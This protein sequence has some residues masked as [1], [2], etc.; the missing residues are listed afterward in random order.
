MHLIRNIL[1]AALAVPVII[2]VISIVFGLWLLGM[3]VTILITGKIGLVV[4]T[5]VS[6]F[7]GYGIVI[8]GGYT[9]GENLYKRYTDK[10]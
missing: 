3:H 5:L 1:I 4:Y 7:I 10:D 9:A 8:G 6:L 2:F